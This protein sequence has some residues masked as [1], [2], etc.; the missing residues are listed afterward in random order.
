MTLTAAASRTPLAYRRGELA[1]AILFALID[2]HNAAVEDEHDFTILM[3]A[4]TGITDTDYE[5]TLTA[6]E[7]DHSGYTTAIASPAPVQGLFGEF[8]VGQ[9][10][11]E[12]CKKLTAQLDAR[13][14]DFEAIVAKL[15]LDAGVTATNFNEARD[16]A[17]R[18][19]LRATVGDDQD[20]VADL[21][22]LEERGYGYG[23]GILAVTTPDSGSGNQ[24][25]VLYSRDGGITWMIRAELPATLTTVAG[26]VQVD[27]ELWVAGDDGSGIVVYRSVDVGLNW[28][29]VD[30]GLS[31]TSTA[32]L[33]VLETTDG[34]LLLAGDAGGEILRRNT[35]GAWTLVTVTGPTGINGLGEASVGKIMACGDDGILYS[36][37][38]DGGSFAVEQ[39]FTS[40]NP[41]ALS[42][43]LELGNGYWFVT[44]HVAA[45]TDELQVSQDDG[46][47]WE[48]PVAATGFQSD[49]G[50]MVEANGVVYISATPDII[51][52][53][54]NGATIG[55]TI[56]LPANDTTVTNFVQT[57][58]G[59]VLAGTTN[60]T[61]FGGIFRIGGRAPQRADAF[62]VTNTGGAYLGPQHGQGGSGRWLAWAMETHRRL[63]ESWQSLGAMMDADG[64]VGTTTYEA[65]IAALVLTESVQEP[66][67]PVLN[68][69]HG[70]GV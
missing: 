67:E 55:G 32:V 40:G 31:E 46:A 23:G 66:V 11:E 15:D 39:D 9:I 42:S 34:T 70:A 65:A 59:E 28:T 51:F 33:D 69:T 1:A 37:T 53:D 7:I 18:L 22:L 61:D 38:D 58:R 30:P 52:T 41:T 25:K 8:T 14:D 13:V 50:R 6:A 12:L 63:I 57:N 27:R 43:F 47:T 17:H 26:I 64:S 49:L 29:E 24:P 56:D 19:M 20:S 16:R 2:Q 21:V 35:A 48:T 3:D 36:S 60:T 45:G 44:S 54:D 5:A 4:D 10:S 68:Y 62:G